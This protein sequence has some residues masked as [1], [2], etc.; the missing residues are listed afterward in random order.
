MKYFVLIVG[1]GRTTRVQVTRTYGKM[2]RANCA[3]MAG[4]VCQ[5]VKFSRR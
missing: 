3:S 5:V 1:A 2:K 4:I